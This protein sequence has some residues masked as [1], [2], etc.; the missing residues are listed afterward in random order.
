MIR[1]CRCTC[2]IAY[3]YEFVGFIDHD[4]PRL[5]D[6]PAS[7]SQMDEDYFEIEPSGYYSRDDVYSERM[8]HGL[9]GASSN[10][11]KYEKI[12]QQVLDYFGNFAGYSQQFLF[13]MERDLNEKKWL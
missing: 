9:G 2:N 6:N 7:I 1:Y 13:K 12:H 11:L 10:T 3:E 4:R 5:T 8:Y